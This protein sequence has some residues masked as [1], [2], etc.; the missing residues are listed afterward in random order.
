MNETELLDLL[1]QA[2]A[3][4]QEAARLIQALLNPPLTAELEAKAR[5]WLR[6]HGE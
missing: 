1:D 6:H 2:Q 5:Y 4:I 3:D